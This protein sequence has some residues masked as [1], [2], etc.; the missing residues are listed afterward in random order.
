MH[1][2]GSYILLLLALW[3]PATPAVAQVD[4]SGTWDLQA[5]ALLIVGEG[6]PAED[7]TFEG[8][9]EVADDG[10][11]ITGT[12]Q[13]ELIDGVPGCPGTLIAD[14]NA[15]FVFEGE[16]VGIDGELTDPQFGQASFSADFLDDGSLDGGYSVLEGPFIGSTGSF[17]ATPQIVAPS[18]A[19]PALTPWMLST[20]ALLLAI[21][22]VV[23]LIRRMA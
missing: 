19:I 23:L 3:I 8:T 5:S 12:A 13:L 18:V 15:F 10:M 4:L 20:L 6:T 1:K 7:C 17:L 22:A 9:A 21:A 11:I 2:V 16:P 14:L